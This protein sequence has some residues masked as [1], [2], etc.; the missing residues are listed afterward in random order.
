[1]TPQKQ[2]VKHDPE[3]GKWGDCY[4]T[5]LA[6]ILGMDAADVPNFCCQV[7]FPDTDKYGLSAARDWLSGRGLAIFNS[8][9][10]AE[11]SFG[12]LLVSLGVHSPGVPAIITGMGPRGVNH[13][14]IAM[15]GKVFCDPHTGGH[16][17]DALT[18]PALNDDGSEFWWVEIIA[19]KPSPACAEAA[20]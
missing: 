14:V 5:C 18:G 11:V 3:N 16:V 1:M 7:E 2:L 20:A 10:L 9:F 17:D 12:E 8:P 19:F 6:V 4:R 13:C 15:D